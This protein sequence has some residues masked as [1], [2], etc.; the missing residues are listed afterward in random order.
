M[1]VILVRRNILCIASD[2]LHFFQVEPLTI[3]ELQNQIGIGRIRQK[4]IETT[5]ASGVAELPPRDTL[6]LLHS[7]CPDAAFLRLFSQFQGVQD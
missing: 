5:Y 4:S 2:I 7:V 6:L 1:I 3:A